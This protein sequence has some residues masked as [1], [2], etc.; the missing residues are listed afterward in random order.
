MKPLK[1]V[2][3]WE[4]D[5]LYLAVDP[6]QLKSAFAYSGIDSE[7]NRKRGVFRVD[8]IRYASTV[9]ARLVEISEGLVFSKIVLLV[10]YP[11]WNAGAAQTVRAAANVWVRL[12]RDLFPRKVEVRKIDPNEWQK[13]FS[14]RG[15]AE[16]T[17]TKDYSLWLARKAYGWEVET[18]DEADAAMI[19]EHGRT[20]PPTPRKKSV[21]KKTATV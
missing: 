3:P 18:S 15:R 6:A 8:D 19:L 17:S 11:K 7:G 1:P 9:E 13:T 10:E 12:V 4:V 14:Y 5:V 20:T 16:G 21:R 2:F